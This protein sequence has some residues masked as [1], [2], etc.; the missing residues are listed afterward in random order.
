MLVVIKGNVVKYVITSISMNMCSYSCI[1]RLLLNVIIGITFIAHVLLYVLP[2]RHMISIAF[3]SFFIIN[4]LYCIVQSC[5][6]HN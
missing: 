2:D 3:V 6:L 4:F 1:K 5:V